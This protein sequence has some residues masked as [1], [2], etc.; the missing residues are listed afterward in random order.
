MVSGYLQLLHCYLQVKVEVK[1]LNEFSKLVKFCKLK[2]L[3]EELQK[4]FDKAD[5]F[6]NYSQALALYQTYFQCQ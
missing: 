3:L 4:A 5:E 6:G 1:N 2:L